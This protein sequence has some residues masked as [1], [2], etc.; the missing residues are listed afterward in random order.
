VDLTD[1]LPSLVEPS[2]NQKLVGNLTLIFIDRLTE[3]DRLI[4]LLEDDLIKP[5]LLLFKHDV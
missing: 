1:Y 5:P 4:K 2:P 3:K